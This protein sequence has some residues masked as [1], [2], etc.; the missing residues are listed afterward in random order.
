MLNRW[1]TQ[2]PLLNNVFTEL[3]DDW[4][5]MSVTVNALAELLSS[6]LAIYDYPLFDLCL[7][8]G[9]IS[10]KAFFTGSSIQPLEFI[11][12]ITATAAMALKGVYISNMLGFE[13]SIYSGESLS[14]WLSINN[15]NEC[16]NQLDINFENTAL[17]HQ[18]IKEK[19]KKQLL[20]CYS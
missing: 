8:N 19:I 13:W 4:P 16:L 10:G 5:L 17:S 18:A 2:Y 6:H 7:T 1:R 20:C 15:Q 9:V 12:A 14:H 11:E 3:I